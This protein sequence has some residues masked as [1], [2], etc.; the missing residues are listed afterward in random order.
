MRIQG[1]ERPPP[2]IPSPRELRSGGGKA[3]QRRLGGSPSKPRRS[4]MPTARPLL[5]Q[6]RRTPCDR[7][8]LLRAQPRRRPIAT[9]TARVTR[10]SLSVKS[11]WG[12]RVRAVTGVWDLPRQ[13]KTNHRVLP[14]QSRR[15]KRQ[16]SHPSSRQ[17]RTSRTRAARMQEVLPKPKAGGKAMA[18][19]RAKAAGRTSLLPLH[20]RCHLPLPP[21]AAPA[22]TACPLHRLHASLLF[23]AGE[24]HAPCI[25]H[26]VLRRWLAGATLYAPVTQW[27]SSDGQA[28][29]FI[30]ATHQ[31][32]ALAHTAAAAAAQS[33]EF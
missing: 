22:A 33:D 20:A 10:L 21:H 27:C 25:C 1:R 19:G 30:I 6:C 13:P 24:S 2:P 7:E 5:C 18:K 9:A 26:T 15:R 11:L 14:S 31:H 23:F 8:A 32:G 3:R 17:P 28:M 16:T 29:L 12:R 4:D